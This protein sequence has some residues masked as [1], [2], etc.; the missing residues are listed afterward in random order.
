MA[1]FFVFIE[2][3]HARVF[4]FTTFITDLV[5]F[6]LM[7]AGVLRWYKVYGRSGV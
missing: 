5:L 3:L 1:F 6:A 4:V 7:L 2:S